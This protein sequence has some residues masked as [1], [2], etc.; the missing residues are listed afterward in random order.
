MPGQ[1]I[2][3]NSGEDICPALL[4][5]THIPLLATPNIQRIIYLFLLLLLLFYN[6][7]INL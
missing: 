4:S 2:T 5:C 3:A 7:T 6:L 1:H